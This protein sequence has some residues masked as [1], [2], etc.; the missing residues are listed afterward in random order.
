MPVWIMGCVLQAASTVK[1][2][3]FTMWGVILKKRKRSLEACLMADRGGVLQANS[4]LTGHKPHLYRFY[5]S[6]GR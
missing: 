1:L 4:V 3:D 2:V 6:G 5:F